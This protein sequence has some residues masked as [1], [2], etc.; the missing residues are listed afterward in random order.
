M[1]ASK[2][3]SASSSARKLGTSNSAHKF[4]PAKLDGLYQ[5]LDGVAW[6]E[7]PGAGEIAQFAGID[8]RTAGKVLKN[9]TLLG[10][11]ERSGPGYSLLVSYPY[12]GT[13]EQK[14]DVVREA[15]VRMPLLT[16]VRQFLRLEDNLP[17]AMRKGATVHKISPFNPTDFNPLL[18]WADALGALKSE[19]VAEDLLDEAQTAKEERHQSDKSKVVAFLSHSSKD[20]PFV[21]R[22]AGDLAANGIGVW[23]DEQKIK[24]GESIP[25]RVSQ[26]L[27]ESDYFLIAISENS[28]D[29]EWVKKELNGALL[30]EIRK[31]AVHV[32]PLKLD[33]SEVP[34]AIADK[35]YADFS[36]SYKTG[37]SE[38]LDALREG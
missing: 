27:A 9:A 5:V 37:L 20:K 2:K 7:T 26:G 33:H 10:L 35:K 18:E 17:S 19:I 38:L 30:K 24:V 22:L 36:E 31:R 12:K 23:L 1:A 14:K 13:L 4:A 8:P 34:D 25:E 29:S 15:L 16:S 32:M 3:A 11:I 21:R 28:A 6:M